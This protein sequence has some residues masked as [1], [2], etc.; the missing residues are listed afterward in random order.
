MST[1]IVFPPVSEIQDFF[2][3][4]ALATYAGDT[5]KT[6]IPG[7]P[8]SK[9][10]RFERG[11]FLYI[12]TYFATDERSGGQ[13]VI[14][15]QNIPVWLMQYQGWCEDD[16]PEVIAFLKEA[17]CIAYE[18]RHFFGGRGPKE[19]N[20]SRLASAPTQRRLQYY[21]GG[22]GTSSTGNESFDK[23]IGREWIEE[24]DGTLH[25]VKV[26]WHRYQGMLLIPETGSRR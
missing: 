9:V 23:F 18:Q 17:L 15:F 24:L 10:Y 4:A 1:K 14:Y 16:D 7:L 12:D 21:N 13:T 20:K 25:G 6:T 5:K 26:F 22:Y 2:F 11:D 3:D 8:S 19:Y